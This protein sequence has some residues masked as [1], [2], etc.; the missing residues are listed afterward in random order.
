MIRDDLKDCNLGNI[1]Y[2]SAQVLCYTLISKRTTA[3]LSL[4]RNYNALF[5]SCYNCLVSCSFH[6]KVMVACYLA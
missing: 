4:V 6:L 5:F 1:Q 2:L 3:A